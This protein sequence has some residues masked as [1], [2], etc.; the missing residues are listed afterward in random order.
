MKGFTS[1]AATLALLASTT[2]AVTV[3]LET[4]QC[5]QSTTIEK[6]DIE[7]DKLNVKQF[8]VCG[9]K[10][11][12][13]TGNVNALTCRAFK[14]TAGQE[15]GSANFTFAQPALIGTN[16]RQIGSIRCDLG[17]AAP[18]NNG[19]T[20]PTPSPTGGAPSGGNT[21]VTVPTAPSQTSSLPSTGT[22]TGG[23]TPAPT[24]AAGKMGLSIGAAIAA[25]AV[26]LL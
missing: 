2:C 19:T 13:S 21:T 5:L 1:I 16:P 14:D 17:S 23:Q 4:T 9:L 25:A 15:P 18:G 24:G 10:I 3:S 11:V 8:A 6:F 20:V 12:S 26:Y 7:T 22:G